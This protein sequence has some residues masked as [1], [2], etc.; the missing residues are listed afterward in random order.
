MG[1]VLR[2]ILSFQLLNNITR[3]TF[4]VEYSTTQDAQDLTVLGN[5]K[6]DDY[7]EVINSDNAISPR[8]LSFQQ[9]ALH[10]PPPGGSS[11]LPIIS[12]AINFRWGQE[13]GNQLPERSHHNRWQDALH[14]ENYEGQNVSF[15]RSSVTLF[16]N[17]ALYQI[18]ID[19]MGL[20]LMSKV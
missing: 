14:L 7:S 11:M 13:A 1:D 15:N 17:W 4:H 9:A 20:I 2:G 19:K 3:A 8:L 10:L 12:R 6:G 16:T 5:N 18:N